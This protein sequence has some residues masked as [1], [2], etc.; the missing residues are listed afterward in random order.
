[1]CSRRL[2]LKLRVSVFRFQ[3]FLGE[4]SAARSID[5]RYSNHFGGAGRLLIQRNGRN[6]VDMNSEGGEEPPLVGYSGLPNWCRTLGGCVR[7]MPVGLGVGARET[8]FA[9]AYTLQRGGSLAALPAV[10]PSPL[11][12]YTNKG[13][14]APIASDVTGKYLRVHVGGLCGPAHPPHILRPTLHLD[15]A[16]MARTAIPPLLVYNRK[17]DGTTAG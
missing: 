4:G 9:C 2:P 14:I 7:L 10:V 17:S 5:V 13:G 6:P 11:R 1:M 3:D 16:Q 12:L 8:F 15:V